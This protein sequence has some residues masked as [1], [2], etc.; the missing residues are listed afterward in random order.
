MSKI[1]IESYSP[2]WLNIFETEAE[3]LRSA[4][5]DED[6]IIEHIGSTSVTGLA[7]K[8]IVDIMIG[9]QK[10]DTDKIVKI[11]ERFGYEH[12]YEDTFRNERLFFTKWDKGKKERL[13]HIHATTIGNS[14]WNDQLAFRNKLRENPSLAKEYEDLKKELA[15]QH[16]NNR[17]GYTEAKTRFVRD[18][19]G[20]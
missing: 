18:V 13:V 16:E 11:I 9:F 7:A 3:K 4:F 8:P 17:D 5:K 19:L 1:V 10:L 20:H 15:V 2:A 14:F 12:W 6:T